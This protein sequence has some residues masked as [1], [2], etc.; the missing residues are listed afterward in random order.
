M[1]VGAANFKKILAQRKLLGFDAVSAYALPGGTLQGT[2]FCEQVSQAHSFWQ[3]AVDAQQPIVPPVP[4][5][6][7]PRPR[8]DHPPCWVNESGAHYQAPSGEELTEL[9][10]DAQT[11]LGSNARLGEAGVGIVYAWNEN[12]EGGW[13]IPTKG[14]GDTRIQAV[15]K[16]LKPTN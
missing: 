8:A 15:A 9:F 11:W 2:P 5:G 7:D 10:G 3:S 14:E 12:S 4:T 16:A 6:W 13:L 1:T